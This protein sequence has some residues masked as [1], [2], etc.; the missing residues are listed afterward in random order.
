[1]AGF[2]KRIRDGADTL[3]DQLRTQRNGVASRLPGPGGPAT[4]A[5][6]TAGKQIGGV[7]KRVEQLLSGKKGSSRPGFAPPFEPSPPTPTE[8]TPLSAPHDDAERPP[9]GVAESEPLVSEMPEP[10]P[11]LTAAPSAPKPVAEPSG[12]APVGKTEGA[13]EELTV[14]Q[15]RARA[16]DAGISGYS[17]M[18]KAKLIAALRET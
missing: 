3:R 6:E 4:R 7:R 18:T 9:Q 12:V 15:L 8:A 16:K 11:D 13:L 14:A 1:M 2:A 17:S 10:V 5:A